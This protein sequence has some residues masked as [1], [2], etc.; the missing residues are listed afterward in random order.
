MVAY[1]ECEELRCIMF[2][3][4]S[5]HGRLAAKSEMASLAPTAEPNC[6]FLL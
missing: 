1:T 5:G 4:R 6:W 3:R 2:I